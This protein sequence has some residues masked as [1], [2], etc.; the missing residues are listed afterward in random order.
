ML[1][2]MLAD[3][4]VDQSLDLIHQY[5]FCCLSTLFPQNIYKNPA[6]CSPPLDIKELPQ[7]I[8]PL[9]HQV[10]HESERDTS[11]EFDVQS[12]ETV[13]AEHAGLIAAPQLLSRQSSL[14]D[15]WFGN[16][17]NEHPNDISVDASLEALFANTDW[18]D[19]KVEMSDANESGQTDTSVCQFVHCP[20]EYDVQAEKTQE[21]K[22]LP[23]LSTVCSA[24]LLPVENV[25]ESSSK[26]GEGTFCICMLL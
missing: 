3:K 2:E 11:L 8:D 20:A 9:F 5:S 23:A 7:S 13:K 6:D 16:V 26:S 15:E 24:D 4:S 12:N 17:S 18:P 10:M 22:S 1:E 14:T 25:G 19:F 21:C